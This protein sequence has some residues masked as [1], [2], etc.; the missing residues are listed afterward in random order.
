[1]LKYNNSNDS[2][3]NNKSDI[4]RKFHLKI[5]LKR[6]QKLSSAIVLTNQKPS[7]TLCQKY[8]QKFKVVP[9]LIEI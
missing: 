1:M 4:R 9:L 8:Q 5:Y 7:L 3:N 6:N 2:D